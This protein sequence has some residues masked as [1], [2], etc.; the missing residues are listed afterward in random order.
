MEKSEQNYVQTIGGP[1]SFRLEY[2]A[3]SGDEHYYGTVSR[4]SPIEAF[5]AY[6]RDDAAWKTICAWKKLNLKLPRVS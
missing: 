3:G 4:N 1:D 6:A 2:R 5:H